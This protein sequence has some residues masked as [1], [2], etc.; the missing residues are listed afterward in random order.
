VDL[1]IDPTLM[2]L[3]FHSGLRKRRVRGQ[4]LV[5]MRSAAT[6]LKCS[7]HGGGGGHKH[8]WTYFDD[9]DYDG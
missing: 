2:P 9:D 3:T 6:C 4:M 5:T 8:E 1:A 7:P